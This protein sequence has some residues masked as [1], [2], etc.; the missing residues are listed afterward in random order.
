MASPLVSVIC[1][2][3]N[4][5]PFVD[6]AIH[7]VLRQTY[8]EI[9]LIVV[10]DASS[11][12][13]VSIIEKLVSSSNQ[14]KFIRL[15]KNVGNCTAFNIGYRQSKG[16]YIIDFAADDVL[17]LNRVEEGVKALE[18]AGIQYGVQ[19]SDALLIDADGNEIGLHSNKYPHDNIPMGDIYKE[20]V[21]RYFISGPTM[22]VRRVVL[23]TL[24]G[25]DEELSY[26]D[27]DFWVRS[28]RRYWYLYI[29]MPLVKRRIL[30]QSMKSR[31]FV[32]G[33]SQLRSTIRVCNKIKELNET[34]EENAALKQ[35]IRYE[36][37]LCLKLFDLS[38][39][40]DYWKLLRSIKP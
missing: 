28:S 37:K 36:I 8:K 35:R 22:L 3:Y 21:N 39:A 25:Y 14:I 23:D 6:E 27:F 7:S 11:D 20:V 2:C 16:M 34:W 38:L 13:S 29:P 9:E 5:A 30:P 24:N 15:D 12:N 32:K 33:S 1:L 19:F 31:Q 10:D 18:G 40:I 26:E 17:L 4:H